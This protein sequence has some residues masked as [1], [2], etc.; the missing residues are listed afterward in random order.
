MKTDGGKSIGVVVRRFLP[1]LGDYGRRSLRA[2]P[3]VFFLCGLSLAFAQAQIS[4]VTAH[5]DIARTGQNLTERI[6]TPATVNPNNFGRLFSQAVDNPI[7]AQ[8]LFVSGVTI[9]GKGVHNVVYVGSSAGTLYAFDADT[10]GG[11]NAV[12]LWETSLLWGSSPT[13]YTILGTPTIDLTTN[14]MYVAIMTQENGNWAAH[15]HAVD[16]TTGGEKFGG[17]TLIQGTVPGTGSGSVNGTL[18]FDP[19]LEVQR[20]GLLLLNGVVYVPYASINDNGAWHGWIF[21]YNAATLKLI[22]IYCTT[23]NGNGGGIWQ[24]GA[25]LAAEVNNPG[26]PYGR[27]FFSTGN[28]TI[29]VA[30]P[31]YKRP[32]LWDEPG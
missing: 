23:P 27:M 2:L 17:P 20:A 29:G 25:G 22:S 6:L 15:L 16:I 14:T 11:G 26:K 9:P 5:N 8:P 12:P 31:L 19:E 18:T 10:N 24:G 28:G 21:A 7:R 30:P 3:T 4:V 32:K 1:K 13:V